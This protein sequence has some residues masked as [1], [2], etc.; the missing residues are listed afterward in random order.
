MHVLITD[1]VVDDAVVVLG[2]VAGVLDMV[3]EDVLDEVDEVDE[4]DEP[5]EEDEVVVS[6]SSLTPGKHAKET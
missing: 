3:D 2:V 4:L 6:G 5:E 1:G